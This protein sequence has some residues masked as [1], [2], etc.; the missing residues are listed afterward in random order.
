MLSTR[1]PTWLTVRRGR[2]CQ[3][4]RISCFV[5][6]GFHHAK[7][8]VLEQVGSGQEDSTRP[9]VYVRFC[10]GGNLP[11]GTVITISLAFFLFPKGHRSV[12]VL[13]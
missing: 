1:I 10:V 8:A 11:P 2:T 13:R 5:F 3:V 7:W 12:A 4:S 6:C 9:V